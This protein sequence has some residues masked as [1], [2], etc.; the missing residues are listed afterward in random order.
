MIDLSLPSFSSFC[1]VASSASFSKS[2][3][4][5]G[6]TYFLAALSKDLDSSSSS[7]SF[8]PSSA[9]LSSWTGSSEGSEEIELL[10]G[11]F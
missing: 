11:S 8:S 9:S 3:L 10:F 5:S 7:F 2:P 6:A 4:S 1:T